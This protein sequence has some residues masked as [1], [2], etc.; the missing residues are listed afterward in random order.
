MEKINP[1][2][3]IT[4]EVW[5]GSKRTSPYL[6]SGFTSGFNFE[7]SDTIRRSI[8]AGR[9]L[10]IVETYKKIEELYSNSN[11]D[12]EDATLLTNHDMERVMTEF[13]RDYNKAKLG[14]SLLLTMPGNPFIYYGEEIGMLGEKPDEYI[15]EPFVWNV[16]GED[17]GQT[18]WEIPYAS[19]SKTVK[20]LFYQENDRASVYMHYK[21][22]IKLRNENSSLNSGDLREIKNDNPKVV[23]FSRHSENQEA[24]I[25]IN[26]STELERIKTLRGINGFEMAYNNFN[27]FKINDEEISLQ[28]H[29][30]FVL[31]IDTEPAI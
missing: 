22:L 9:D 4:G 5:G 24:I 12:F 20:P 19:S 17:P 8:L 7:M 30:V 11:N 16:E 13:N 14:A 29:A 28:P 27:V 2:V 10:G 18:S 23:T 15:R 31:T 26:L 3:I 25:I 6:K 1:D 21:N